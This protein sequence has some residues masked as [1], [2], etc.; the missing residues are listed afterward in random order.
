VILIHKKQVR[1]TNSKDDLSQIS[2]NELCTF[3]IIDR[4]YSDDSMR[5]MDDG[6]EEV[7]FYRCWSLAGY[8]ESAF[9]PKAS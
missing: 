1:K 2:S 8:E 3:E 4:R 6:I 7:G 5:T 9:N